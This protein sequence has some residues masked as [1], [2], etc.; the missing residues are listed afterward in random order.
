V[1]GQ[2]V[3]VEAVP[4]RYLRLE[5]E[6]SSGDSITIAM[7]MRLS[8]TTWPRTGSVTVDRGPLSYSVKIGERWQRYGGTEEWPEWE[9][10]PTTPWNYGLVLVGQP[11]EAV[12]S[13][14]ENGPV[15]AQPW[16]PQ[17]APLEITARAKRL[18]NWGLENETVAELQP[19]PIKSREPI[20]SITLIPLGCARL[21]MAC[22]PV[23]GEGED[24]RE[25]EQ[26]PP[27]PAG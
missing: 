15:A 6:W 5:R 14:K 25:W 22:L 4:G 26:T 10:F 19:S 3:Q 7:P 1:N 18:P 12:F 9:V 27:P 21:R 13:V 16:T 20:E 2:S 24:A 17:A 11:L 23:I 8:L